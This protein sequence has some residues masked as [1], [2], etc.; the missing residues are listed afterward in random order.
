MAPACFWHNSHGSWRHPRRAGR[1][2]A[3]PVAWAGAPSGRPGRRDLA[4]SPFWQRDAR[5]LGRAR[6][7]RARV[8]RQASCLSVRLASWCILKAI[9]DED[10][11]WTGAWPHARWRRLGEWRRSRGRGAELA[12]WLNWWGNTPCSLLLQ[13]VGSATQRV[14][15]IILH[16]IRIQPQAHALGLYIT[17]KTSLDDARTRH[18]RAATNASPIRLHLACPNHKVTRR[19][20]DPEWGQ[21]RP[22]PSAI[23]RPPLT[24]TPH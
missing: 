8:Q 11:L 18:A 6:R 3:A 9:Q 7:K 1:Y 2:L 24:Y 19:G 16:V 5:A 4:R 17:L 22:L 20:V 10:S 12:V 23:V 14:A 21:A 13:P 15:E